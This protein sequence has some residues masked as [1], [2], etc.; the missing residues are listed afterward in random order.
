MIDED[1]DDE[2]G[3]DDAIRSGKLKSDD[4][5]SYHSKDFLPKESAESLSALHPS[6]SYA[7][8]RIAFKVNPDVPRAVPWVKGPLIGAG[9]F[10][11]V[12]YGVNCTT[13]EIMAVKQVQIR[14]TQDESAAKA[15]RKMLEAL[16][17]EI[18][19]LKDLNHENIVHYLGF[20]V[21]DDCINVF[22]EY[23][24]G[25]SVASA[26][27]HMGSFEEPL[28]RSIV[29]QVLCGL[30]YLH[31]R[32]IIHR[33]IK[34]GNILIDEDGWTKISDFGIS[35]KNKYSMAY[36]YNSR[37]SIQGSIYWMA[38]EVIKAKG[39]SAKVDVWSL[40]CVVLEMFTGSHPWRQLDEIQTM[41]RLGREDKPPLPSFLSP[42][43]TDFLAKC[44]TIDPEVRPTASQL[45][46]HPFCV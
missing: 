10:G 3:D 1:G 12:Y 36:R 43:A 14:P 44:F 39:Y 24:S 5:L 7:D 27:A 37:M 42:E 34:G 35:K 31:E 2:D 32:A 45:L 38:P 41:W 8:Y 26:L 17:R 22:L 46:I 19:L 18:S 6:E 11:K 40:G 21:Q 9:S 23:V 33:D 15:R 29:S 30:E 4:E 25:G 16:H 28:V 20:D 13:G